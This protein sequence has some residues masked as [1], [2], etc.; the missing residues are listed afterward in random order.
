MFLPLNQFSALTDKGIGIFTVRK[1]A[2]FIAK[3][4]TSFGLWF[5]GRK[6]HKQ[7]ASC[8]TA[9]TKTKICNKTSGRLYR[10]IS[11]FTCKDQRYLGK[12]STSF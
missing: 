11:V 12:L 9:C 4:I 6:T 3:D 1:T 5:S 7:I 2:I 8:V 10:L